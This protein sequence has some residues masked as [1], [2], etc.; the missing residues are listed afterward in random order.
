METKKTNNQSISTMVFSYVMLTFTNLLSLLPLQ[1]LLFFS[2]LVSFFLHKVL[3]YR[4]AIV[5]ENLQKSFPH[6]HLRKRGEIES[7]FYNHFSEVLFEVIKLKTIKF[8]EL[9]KRCSFSEESV[10]L[11]NEYY[12]RGQSIMIV[13]G[14]NGNWEWAGATFPLYNQ[15]QII[16]AYRPLRDKVFD[17]DT[18]KMRKRTGNILVSMK[19]LPREMINRRNIVNATALI[20]DQTPSKNNAFWI[21]FLNQKT[22][23]F[24]GPEVLSQKFNTP[25]FWASVKRIKRGYY[26]IVVELITDAPRSFNPPGS[27]T[28]LFCSYLERDIQNQPEGWLWSH[29]RWK[30][31]PLDDL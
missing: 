19:K 17:A 31:L 14:H 25:L 4:L 29:R 5:R 12:E 9:K 1:F 23:F 10:K 28:K 20:A 8:E 13:M 3:R 27:L 11:L 15:H 30:H 24:K 18:L 6:V 16:T 22:P 7:L 2:P 21:H 26:S